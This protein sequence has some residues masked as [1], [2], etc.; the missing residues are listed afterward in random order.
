MGW[1][2]EWPRPTSIEERREYARTCFSELGLDTMRNTTL[3]LDKMSNDF[4]EAFK[5]WPTAYYV[6]DPQ[7]RLLFRDEE[8][9]DRPGYEMAE[10]D[11]RHLIGFVTELAEQR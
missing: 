6:M 4:N 5:S 10:F 3:V 7:G 11:I 9:G 2:V 8:E 1:S